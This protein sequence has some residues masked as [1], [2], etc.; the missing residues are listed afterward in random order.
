[1]P[2]HQ[3]LI[4]TRQRQHRKRNILQPAV[5]HN[6]QTPVPQKRP[7]LTEDHPAQLARN[8]GYRRIRPQTQ[9]L[10]KLAHLVFN[11]QPCGQFPGVDTVR[12]HRPEIT[13]LLAQ[14]IFHEQRVAVQQFRLNLFR[15]QQTGLSQRGVTRIALA[16]G[17]LQVLIFRFQIADILTQRCHLRIAPA[18]L[19]QPRTLGIQPVCNVT[20]A[21][22][23]F[24]PGAFSRYAP[25]FRQHLHQ[26]ARPR[27]LTGFQR[28]CHRARAHQQVDVK[29][30]R[31]LTS[32]KKRCPQLF[33]VR[34]LSG[35]F[36]DAQGFLHASPR[37]RQIATDAFRT[38][39]HFEGHAFVTRIAN[40]AELSQRLL[41][42]L[43]RIAC[44]PGEQRDT[45]QRQQRST[46]RQ[47]GSQ[48]TRQTQTL[49]QRILCLL[50]TP[51]GSV[52]FPPELERPR[53][54]AAVSQRVC[55]RNRLIHVVDRLPRLIQGELKI[56][57]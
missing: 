9:Q 30:I 38:R 13:A 24:R 18:E 17:R 29:T 43:H 21:L 5:R 26:T 22:Q 49:L 1:M 4:G 32:G 56:S 33:T 41:A 23:Q 39:N 42:P 8:R 12:S 36:V 2:H 45:C 40:G 19:Q 14:R 25:G 15:R 35:R 28:L 51:Q 7:C 57:Q 50:K 47:A 31:V 55:R 54:Q 3:R 53:L 11:E 10:R 37:F 44:L 16:D 48:G 6:Q 34:S 20:L 27:T 46:G 52:S